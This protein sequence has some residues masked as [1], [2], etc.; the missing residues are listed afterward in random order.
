MYFLVRLCSSVF[1]S[2]F[3]YVIVIVSRSEICVFAYLRILEYFFLLLFLVV[4]EFLFIV[5]LS[6]LYFVFVY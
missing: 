3:L 2:R 5:D 1:S 6:S 4:F